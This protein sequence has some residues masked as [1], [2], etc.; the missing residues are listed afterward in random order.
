[1]VNKGGDL[2]TTTYYGGR[3]THKN[4]PLVLAEATTSWYGDTYTYHFLA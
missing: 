2:E 1:M 3:H 4:Q